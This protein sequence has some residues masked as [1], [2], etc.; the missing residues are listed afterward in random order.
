V[1]G[2]LTVPIASSDQ[3][4]GLVVVADRGEP[5]GAADQALLESVVGYLAPMLRDRQASE[6]SEAQLRQAQKMEALGVLAGGIAHDFNNILQA[7]HGFASLAAEDA[8]PEGHLAHDL[9]RILKAAKRGEDL[10]RRILLFSRREEQEVR[11]LSL[12]EVVTEAVEFLQSTVPS[13]IRVEAQLAADTGQVLG[14][15]SQLN[16]VIMNLATNAVHA[17]ETDGGTVTFSLR[18]SR[19]GEDRPGLHA[20]LRDKDLLSLEVRDTGCGMDSKTLDRLFDPFFTTKEVG[21]GTGLGL[22]MVHGIVVAHG[23]DVHIASEPAQGTVVTVY[24]PRHA[25]TGEAEL[26]APAVQTGNILLVEDDPASAEVAASILEVGGHRV[27]V[28]HDGESA[29]ECLRAEEDEYDLVITDVLMPGVNGLQ[30]AEGAASL[31]PGLPV[32]LMTGS[33]DDLGRLAGWRQPPECV[34]AVVQKPFNG[35]LLRH[36]VARALAPEETRA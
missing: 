14:D 22:S 27:A 10:V 26:P 7:I 28:R 16:Q 9:D 15:L 17:M 32:M 25:P 2:S 18:R 30:V 19:P 4:L 23:G 35:D 33:G 8:E 13:K 20:F 11:P 5:Y 1:T 24:L 29:L 36:A 21:R 12:A 6:T 34:V 3:V 31:Q